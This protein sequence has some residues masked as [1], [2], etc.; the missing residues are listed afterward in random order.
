MFPPKAKNRHIIN[1]TTL[2]KLY[3]IDNQSHKL[4][5]KITLRIIIKK[6][7]LEIMFM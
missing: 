2:I 6:I 3:H 7:K 4:L 5:S 1:K